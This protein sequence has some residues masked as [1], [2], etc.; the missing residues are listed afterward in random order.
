MK[1]A[2]VGCLIPTIIIVAVV[3]VAWFIIHA[4]APPK[5]V[6]NAKPPLLINVVT[7]KKEA[8]RY[9]VTSQGTVQPKV[10]TTLVAEV[11]GRVV[12]VSDKFLSGAWVHK[13][14]LLAQIDPADYRTALESARADLAQAKAA[15][16]QEKAQS[17]V[18]KKEWRSVS[19]DKVTAIALRKPQLAS[20]KA[21]VES[22]QARL[23]QAQ[24][25]L[26][27]TEIRAP[28]DGLVR[29]RDINP[30]QYVAPGTKLGRVDDTAMAEV[31]LPVSDQQLDWLGL[32]DNDGSGARVTLS[33]DVAGQHYQWSARLVHGAGVLDD[34][35]RMSFIIADV[36]DPYQRRK[37]EGQWLKF[38]TFVEAQ[39]VSD[40]SRELVVVPVE[41]LRG[42]EVV[43]VGKDNRIHHQKVSVART[44]EKYA[45]ISEGL[46]GG[47]RIS[48][49]ALPGVVNGTQVAIAPPPAEKEQKA[50]AQLTAGGH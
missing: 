43:V 47:E 32:N 5:R 44:D 6:S 10:S 50:N 22:M 8:V 30:G 49:T 29:S 33:H 48:Q 23:E 34:Q 42:D 19:P 25:N 9:Q 4:K 11:G 46:Q 37:A 17:E 3:V 20:A 13:G 18:A 45:Y 39:L 38:G 31:R 41:T 27:R 16:E 21:K 36:P 15:Y 24:R 1:R 28:Y 14:D 26:A 12:S 7:A 2:T 35:S 40:V